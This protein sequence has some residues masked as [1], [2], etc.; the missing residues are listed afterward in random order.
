[1]PKFAWQTYVTFVLAIM[2]YAIVSLTDAGSAIE[3]SPQTRQLLGILAFA[4]TLA[5]NQLKP[6][7]GDTPSK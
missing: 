3:L 5:A 2:S 6:I 7:G 1:M 4:V